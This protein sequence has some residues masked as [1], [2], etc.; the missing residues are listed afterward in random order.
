VTGRDADPQETIMIE[1]TGAPRDLQEHIA[2]LAAK[3][4]LMRIGRPINKD[5][6]LHPLAR[7]QFQG[8][9]DEADRRAFLFSDVTDGEGHTYDIPVLVGGLAASSEIYATGLGV[10][11]DQIG[12]VWMEAINEPIP[13]V[14]VK[15]APCQEVVITGDALK[16]P[17]EG[18]SRLPVPVSTPGFDAAPY[19]TATLC[20]TRDP[21][22]GVQ[23][24]RPRGRR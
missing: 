22:N 18:L 4:L 7:W 9:L 16:R 19:L 2:R 21:E 17:G 11:V 6:E 14:T 15:D 8:G 10:P 1:T 20:V 24:M 5:T 13:P 23:N 12:K 3:G